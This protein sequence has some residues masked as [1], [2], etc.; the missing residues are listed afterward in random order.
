MFYH[1]IYPLHDYFSFLR[2]FKYITFRSLF[3]A[4][5]ALVFVLIFGNLMI[6]WLRSLKFKEE[7]RELGP[8]SHKSKAGTP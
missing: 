1:L 4:I 7:I 5:T 2:L 3:A 6:R 8:Q